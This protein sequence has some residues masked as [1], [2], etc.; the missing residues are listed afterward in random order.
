M[1]NA[2]LALYEDLQ[3]W[4]RSRKI[5]R[6]RPAKKKKADENEPGFHFIAYVPIDGAVWKL[7][8][9]RRQPENLGILLF[10]FDTSE[11]DVNAEQT[12]ARTRKNCGYP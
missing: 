5:K 1:L 7:D 2:D 10:P 4:E 3:K 12:K 9:L 6:K 11:D 8:G